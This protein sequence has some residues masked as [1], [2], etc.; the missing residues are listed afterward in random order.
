M[1]LLYNPDIRIG[2]I[3]GIAQNIRQALDHPG[4]FMGPASQ[5]D[6]LPI[7]RLQCVIQKVRGNLRLHGQQ[8]HYLQ[9]IF[10]L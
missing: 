2:I 8:L 10:P 9:L 3:Q 7:N 5:P 1:D 6:Y 4:D